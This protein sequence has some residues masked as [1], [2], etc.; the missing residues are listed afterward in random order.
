MK[1]IMMIM[2]LVAIGAA[3]AEARDTAE[4]RVAKARAILEANKGTPIQNI[5]DANKNAF[6]CT[7]VKGPNVVCRKKMDVLVAEYK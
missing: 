5:I 3:N 2:A 1:K 4:E 7:H 6:S